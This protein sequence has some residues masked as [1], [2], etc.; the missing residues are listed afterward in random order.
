MGLRKVILNTSMLPQEYPLSRYQT[1]EMLDLLIS[2]ADLRDA[3]AWMA[4]RGIDLKAEIYRVW[5]DR[6]RYIRC[7]LFADME[8]EDEVLMRLTFDLDGQ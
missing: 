3:N 4:E 5:K 7:V 1:M 6:Q 2:A 8:H